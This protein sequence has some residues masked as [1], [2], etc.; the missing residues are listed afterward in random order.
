[1]VQINFEKKALDHFLQT[2]PTDFE[3]INYWNYLGGMQKVWPFSCSIS[4]QPKGGWPKPLV[5]QVKHRT[6]YRACFNKTRNLALVQNAALV[7]KINMLNL[8]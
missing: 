6:N 2:S 3:V 4:R 5:I 8:G 1:M 7:M